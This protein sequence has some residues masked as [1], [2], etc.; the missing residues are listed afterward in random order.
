[1]PIMKQISTTKLHGWWTANTVQF[2]KFSETQGNTKTTY[3]NNTLE[4]TKDT[5]FTLHARIRLHPTQ[6]TF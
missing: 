1:M 2:K 4:T 6:I 3:V 5:S